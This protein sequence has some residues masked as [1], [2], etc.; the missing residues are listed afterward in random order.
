MDQRVQGCPSLDSRVVAVVMTKSSA[1]E[2]SRPGRS[3]PLRVQAGQADL[4]EA[5]DYILNG[6][7]VGPHQPSDHRHPF[8]PA[9]AGNI[10]A[11]R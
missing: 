7:L 11:L 4:A 3:R 9:E 10:I 2:L 6:V 5:A 1:S 8:P